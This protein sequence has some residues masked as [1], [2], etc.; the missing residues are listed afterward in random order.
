MPGPRVVCLL[1]VRNGEADLP[2]YLASVAR[3][4]DAVVALDDGSTDGTRRLLAAAPLV[5]ALLVNPPRADYRGWDDGAN[6]AR[7]LAAAA[8]LAPDWVVSLDADERIAADDAAALRH[9]VATEARPGHAYGFAL[10]RMWGDLGQSVPT[11]HWVYRLF[12]F[13][14]GLA[15]PDKRLHFAPVP[16]AI[17]RDRWLP[18]TLR[19]QHLGA[20]D[21]GRCAARF[22][23]YRQA[24]LDHLRQYRDAD[25]WPPDPADLRPWH[26][27][28]PD[29]PVLIDPPAGDG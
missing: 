13:A 3:F 15:F 25:L 11:G 27:R 8:A 21:R 26:P 6:R 20:V 16:T 29:L 1:P 5:Q 4:A 7:L 12:A 9:F 14:P 17:P 10:H 19:I 24:D 18:T 2:G 22:E 23:K 28:P